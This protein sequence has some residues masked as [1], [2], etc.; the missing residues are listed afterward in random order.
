MNSSLKSRYSLFIFFLF[1]GLIAAGI[2]YSWSDGE[3]NRELVESPVPIET[4]IY[5]GFTLSQFCIEECKVKNDQ[6]F[7]QILNT[8]GL[9]HQDV[10][11][12]VENTSELFDPRNLRAGRSYEVIY[13]KKLRRSRKLNLSDDSY[14]EHRI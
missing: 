12:L 6:F 5:R 2:L 4:Q 3:T 14:K 10:H 7:A 9:D 1:I 13:N 8:C 11:Q